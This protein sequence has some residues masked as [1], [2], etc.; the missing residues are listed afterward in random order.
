[1]SNDL[2]EYHIGMVKVPKGVKAK[3][4]YLLAVENKSMHDKVVEL[5]V[6]A[7]EGIKVDVETE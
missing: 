5:L 3:F 6:K 4:K 7:T 2:V 1:M